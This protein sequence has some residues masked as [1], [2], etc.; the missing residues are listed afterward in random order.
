MQGSYSTPGSDPQADLT[1]W[2]ATV[3]AGEPYG[4]EATYI[5]NQIAQYHSPYY[6]LDGKYGTG[7]EAPSP[8][9]IANGFTDDLFPVDEALRYYNLERALYPS[10]PLQLVDGDFG[11]MRANNKP[12]D[13]ALLSARIERFFAYYLNPRK[14][15]R[16]PSSGVT[17]RIE[18]CPKAAPSGP[19][20]SA[21]TWA[22]LHPGDAP[23]ILFRQH[24]S[25]LD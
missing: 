7:L 5:A 19:T 10:D 23:A 6:L 25:L 24:G 12:A 13:V 16:P 2:Y 20:Y 4:T 11:H 22:G 18:T 17:A 21:S 9:L 3:T 15:G 1:T 8:L 14:P